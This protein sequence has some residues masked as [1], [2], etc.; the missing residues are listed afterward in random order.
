MVPGWEGLA[1]V[2]GDPLGPACE[3]HLGHQVG[4]FQGEACAHE[5]LE[6]VPSSCVDHQAHGGHG[7]HE[8]PGAHE[9]LVDDDQSL[10]L[11]Q[12]EFWTETQTEKG[13][14]QRKV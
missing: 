12:D 14:L 6:E 4:A 1:D 2:L 7:D 8:D 3:D 9:G 11:E 10:E 13:E 5:Y